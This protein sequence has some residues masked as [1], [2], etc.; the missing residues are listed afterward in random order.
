MHVPLL[1]G[2]V[3]VTPDSFS[4]GGLYDVRQTAVEHACTMLD[5]GA[6]WIDVG[7][8]STRPGAT[9]VPADL[10][11]VRVLPVIRDLLDVCP[12]ANI[13]VDTSKSIVAEQALAAGARM[14]NDVSAGRHDPRMFDVVAAR[15]APIIL[16]H[17]QGD[18]T[19]MQ[20]NPTYTNVSDEVVELLSLRVEAARSAGIGN[21]LIDPG[22]GFGKT[23]DHNLELLRNLDVFSGLADGVV[24]GISRKRFIGDITGIAIPAERDVATALI[25]ALL[26]NAKPT[27]LRVHN[28]QLNAQ[29]LQLAAR[30]MS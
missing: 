21:V 22:I 24:L 14:I 30:V 19:T 12:T 28:V 6:D 29:L 3:N 18:P 26:W 20:Q 2:V 23:L 16:M 9:P 7:G 17:M 8:E 5:Q 10:E 15:G 11:C 4:D 27:V 25:H 1:M 13:S